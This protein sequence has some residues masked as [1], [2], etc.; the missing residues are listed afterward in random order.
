MWQQKG[1]KSF[2]DRTLFTFGIRCKLLLYLVVYLGLRTDCVKNSQ[3][4]YSHCDLLDF[5]IILIVT[6]KCL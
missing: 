4:T 2:E 1:N 6:V 5:S 3:D